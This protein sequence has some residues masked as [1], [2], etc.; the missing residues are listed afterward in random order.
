MG[1]LG[2][3][4]AGLD[5]DLQEIAQAADHEGGVVVAHDQV[6]VASQGAFLDETGVQGAAQAWAAADGVLGQ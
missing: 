4:E 2:H 1:R 6:L 3:H 5:R